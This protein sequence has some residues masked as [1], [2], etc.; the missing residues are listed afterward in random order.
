MCLIGYRAT[1]VFRPENW[2]IVCG[3]GR[4]VGV[5]L[6]ADDPAA[7]HCELVYMGLVP[8]ARGQGR[9]VQIARHA[10][11][12]AQKIRRRARGAWRSMPTNRPALAM[13]GAAGFTVWDRRTVYVRF[14]GENAD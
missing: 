1:G 8:E 14:R 7:G 13:Y 9:G 4:D 10:L 5:L 3:E 2:L 11:R 12:L 6:M